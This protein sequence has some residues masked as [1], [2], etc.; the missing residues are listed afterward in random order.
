VSPLALISAYDDEPR[1][2]N[3]YA[4][5]RYQRYLA[6]LESTVR[7][8]PGEPVANPEPFIVQERS[9][10]VDGL[11]VAPAPEKPKRKRKPARK[12][13]MPTLDR[14]SVNLASFARK[15]KGQE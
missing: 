14:D 13:D 9:E 4:D 11:V 7:G 1:N 15:V 8:E 6:H 5:A 10:L 3:L 12:A 2:H